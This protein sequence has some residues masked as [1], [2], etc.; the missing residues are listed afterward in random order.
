MWAVSLNQP[1]KWCVHSI[2]QWT[3]R[4]SFLIHTCRCHLVNFCSCEALLSWASCQIA[5]CHVCSLFAAHWSVPLWPGSQGGLSLGYPTLKPFVMS[6]SP[7]DYSSRG[8]SSKLLCKKL[9]VWSCAAGCCTSSEFTGSVVKQG[10]CWER[11]KV[12]FNSVI[13]LSYFLKGELSMVRANEMK[14]IGACCG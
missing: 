12:G 5:V 11:P 9:S 10:P 7:Q 6:N 1:L 2:W 3:G 14:I 4:P 13:K 8:N